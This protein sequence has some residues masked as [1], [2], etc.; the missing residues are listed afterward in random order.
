[1]ADILEELQQ[2]ERALHTAFL[3][4]SAEQFLVDSTENL[5]AA[6]EQLKQAGAILQAQIAQLKRVR[7]E[8]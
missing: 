6:R 8:L 7:E 1:M 3:A 4:M 5:K 2:A